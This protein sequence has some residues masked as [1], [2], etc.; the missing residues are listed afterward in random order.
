MEVEKGLISALSASYI[1]NICLD[2]ATK[3]D[4]TVILN[5]YLKYG[6]NISDT[7][8]CYCCE[9]TGEVFCSEIIEVYEKSGVSAEEWWE[10]Y[11]RIA[12][13]TIIVGVLFDKNHVLTEANQQLEVQLHSAYER[14]NDLKTPFWKKLFSR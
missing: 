11:P 3:M 10:K 6:W 2:C 4:H 8:R 14:I 13:G 7:G 9:K 12:G 1:Q 5:A